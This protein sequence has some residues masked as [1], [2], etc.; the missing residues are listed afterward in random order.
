MPLDTTKPLRNAIR[1]ME[2]LLNEANK[3][4]KTLCI[5]N[6]NWQEKAEHVM[7]SVIRKSLEMRVVGFI[8][9]F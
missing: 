8:T 3:K 1:E 2:N 7:D 6:K 5:E 9:P 4:S